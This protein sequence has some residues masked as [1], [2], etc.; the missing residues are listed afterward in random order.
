ME[1]GLCTGDRF[2]PFPEEAN[3][4]ITD[5]VAELLCAPTRHAAAQLRSEGYPADRVL[6]TGN[7]G[8]DA[9]LQMATAPET[10]RVTRLRQ[11]I[12]G[13]RIAI[14]T[15]HRRENFG[16]PLARICSAILALVDRDPRTCV[17]LPVH[18][19]PNVAAAVEQQLGNHP[20]I[21]LTTP[22]E[23]A[24]FVAMMKH[25]TIILSDSGGVQEEA[26][27]L[28][29][30][31]L[32]LRDTTERQEAVLAGTA[33]LVGTDTDC[34]VG[35]A[36]ALLEDEAARRAMVST[37]N[38]FGDGYASARIVEALWNRRPHRR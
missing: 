37:G 16:E 5:T 31:V 24:D 8:V 36:T 11:Q 6:V 35:T 30:P 27:S 7:T 19:N 38:P 26:P 12:A 13:R 15:T 1:A 22:L 23:Y 2:H 20:G 9:L 18:P 10:L 25:A 17:V 28:G 14:V 32:V 4:K 33:R 3:R 21:L 34:I 29:I